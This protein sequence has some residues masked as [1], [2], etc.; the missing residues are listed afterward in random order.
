MRSLTLVL[1]CLF[2]VNAFAENCIEN[3]YHFILNGQLDPEHF[4]MMSMDEEPNIVAEYI[5]KAAVVI[6]GSPID[7]AGVIVAV[8]A[9][10]AASVP[11]KPVVTRQAV[12]HSEFHLQSMPERIRRTGRAELFGKTVDL[13]EICQ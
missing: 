1:L 4:A 13:W 6:A 2:M 11:E 7:A 9:S 3:E 5:A 10:N 12:L 8:A